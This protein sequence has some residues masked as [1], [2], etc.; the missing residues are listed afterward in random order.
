MANPSYFW[1]SLGT[2]AYNK[3]HK[4]I[5]IQYELCCVNVD[6]E[7]EKLPDNGEFKKV[8]REYI[9]RCKAVRARH[10]NLNATLDFNMPKVA[11]EIDKRYNICVQQVIRNN[12]TFVSEE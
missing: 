7:F 9:E 6:E 10:R 3:N 1:F 11:K 12:N 8:K 4:Q 5:D 2:P